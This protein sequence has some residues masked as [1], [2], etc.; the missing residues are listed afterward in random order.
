MLSSP[1]KPPWNTLWPSPSLRFTHQVKFSSSFW[2]M[3]SRN[4]RSPAPLRRLSR[5]IA[6]EPLFDFVEIE[7][8][9]PQHARECLALDAPLV[10]VHVLGAELRVVERISFGLSERQHL[11][12]IRPRLRH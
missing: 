12:R 4:S 8:L 3:R 9:A 5:R 2:N 7:L 11:V 6:V 1:R 10:L